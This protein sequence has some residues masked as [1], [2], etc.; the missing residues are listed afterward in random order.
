MDIS[1]FLFYISIFYLLLKILSCLP[2]YMY[3]HSINL[4]NGNIL[5]IHSNGIIIYDSSLKNEIKNVSN[6]NGLI[7]KDI[8]SKIEIC[9]FSVEDN[10]Y[11]IA[12]IN[13]TIYIFDW[14]GNLKNKSKNYEDKIIGQYY[15]LIPIQKNNN[16]YIYMLGFNDKIKINLIF[17][18]Y[19]D[20]S[21]EIIK[22][23]Y[24][25]LS[26]IYSGCDLSSRQIEEYGLSCQVMSKTIKNDYIVCFIAIKQPLELFQFFINPNNFSVIKSP[27]PKNFENKG[28]PIKV[29]KSVVS[30]DKKKSLICFSY[31]QPPSFCTIYSIDYNNFS[32]VKNYDVK[33]G[34]LYNKFHLYYMRETGQFLFFCD[35]NNEFTLAILD[36]DFSKIDQLYVNDINNIASIFFIYSY[37]LSNYYGISSGSNKCYFKGFELNQTK[38]IS[39]IETIFYL[40]EQYKSEPITT[41]LIY[42][43]NVFSTNPTLISTTE[44]ISDSSEINHDKNLS[45]TYIYTSDSHSATFDSTFLK[46][47]IDTDLIFDS[48]FSVSYSTSLNNEVIETISIIKDVI[49]FSPEIERLTITKDELM[50][51]IPSMMDKIKIG[52]IYKKIGYDYN[53]LIYPTNSTFLSS[54]THVNFTE[55]EEILRNHYGLPESSIITFLQIE[56]ENDNSNSLINQVEYQVYDQNKTELDLSLCKDINIQVFHSIKNNSNINFDSANNFKKSG[57]DVFNLNDSF[58]NDICEPYSDSNNDIILEDRIKYIYQNYS[59]CEEGC[60]YDKVD[61]ENMTIICDCKVKENITTSLKP[62]HLEHTEGS[63]TNFDVIKCY[64]LVFS[65][66]DKFNNIGFWILGTLVIVHFPILFFYFYKGI[67]P[68]KE[69]IIKQ[70]KEYG[71]IKKNKTKNNNIKNKSKVKGKKD[72][73]IDAPPLRKNIN[74]KGKFT[75]RNVK[76]IDNSSSINIIKSTNKNMIQGGMDRT[77]IGK[78]NDKKFI[79][80]SRKSKSNNKKKCKMITTKIKKS[81]TNSK[82]KTKWSTKKSKKA[83]NITFL[84]TQ[85]A[86]DNTSKK[87]KNKNLNKFILMN[88][89]LNL[90]S[91]ENYI[92][93][94]SN[95]ILNNYTFK[96]ALKYDKR[97]LCVIFYIF[98]LSKQI[99]FHTFLY[100]SP[101]ELF[102]LRLC[103]FIF[104]ISS[105]LALNALFYF[106][107]NISKK[108]RYAKNL[109]L[110][111]FSENI[112]VV[113]LSTLVGFVLLTFLAK[114]SNSTNAIREVFMKE[115]ERIKAVKNYTITEKRKKE[116]LKE[117]DEILEKYKKKVVFLIIIEFILVIFFWYFVTAFC[118]V[119]KSTQISWLFDSFLSILSRAILELLISLGLA[120]LYMMS[121]TGEI[122]CLYKFVMFLY[123]FG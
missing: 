10:G 20:S 96:E 15:T 113:F 4:I 118:H 82:D 108:Y 54:T 39:P 91:H 60:I 41:D 101:I 21:N 52:K 26:D 33:C 95:I 40:T 5:I 105:D 123:N 72:K 31:P 83:K 2:D 50:N 62:I 7:T 29:I 38:K 106:N 53:V 44:E 3:P 17:F 9:R 121:I 71:Y 97:E 68:V 18:N 102:P 112:T 61:F 43:L 107:D 42:N 28:N 115:E 122:H 85:G 13:Q 66:K 1:I 109:F 65:F 6:Q 49:L 14:E 104:I 51:E 81:K 55:C 70:M 78:L 47:K 74:K 76:F 25:S 90:S 57:V 35:Y 103:L 84:Q 69:Y 56:I 22:E 79:K 48:T 80:E 67:K 119:Y 46:T 36:K 100:R 110:F 11:I 98:A 19:K 87:N 93:P 111:T 99:I 64:K 92:P 120:K 30:S 116:I 75:I 32:D 73:K 114:L 117:I 45:T 88:M 16:E 86:L 27:N 94:E 12:L 59:L 37:N 63:S 34:D 58:F 89:D 23:I 8:L 24:L 77:I